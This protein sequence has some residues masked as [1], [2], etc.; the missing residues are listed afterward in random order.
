MQQF[1]CINDTLETGLTWVP[2]EGRRQVG[3]WFVVGHILKSLVIL[4][5]FS[6]MAN[7]QTVVTYSGPVSK[8]EKTQVNLIFNR[9]NF[10]SDS[11]KTCKH[12]FLEINQEN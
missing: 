3:Q 11:L 6:S 10:E 1:P 4:S 9:L 12:S 2:N 7:V 5:C 8:Q